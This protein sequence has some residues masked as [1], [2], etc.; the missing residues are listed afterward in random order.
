[1]FKK[2][3]LTMLLFAFTTGFTSPAYA[4]TNEPVYTQLRAV[5]ANTFNE[6]R[7]KITDAYFDLRN[8]YELNESIDAFTANIILDLATKGYNYLPD[9]LS[10]KNYYN[11]LKTSIEKGIKYPN[12]SSNFTEIAKGI[13]DF[14]EKTNIKAIT[15]SVEA[16]PK[17]WNAPLNV[18]LRWNVKDPTG[19]KIPS[20]NYT[21]W[22][23]EDGA[24]KILGD[25]ISLNHIFSEEW[26]FSI[27]LDVKSAHKNENGYTD[28]LPFSSRADITI[29]EKVASLIIKVNSLNLRNSSELNFTPDE[30]IYWLLFDATSSTPTSG[31][32]F[33]KTTW[34][35]W[36]GI[37]RE[38]NWDPRVERV[39]YAREWEFTV[40]LLLKTN[41]L[42]EIE[43]IFVVNVH[44]PIATIRASQDQGFLWDKFTFSAQNST[45]NKNLS[46]SWEII[47]LNKDEVI[48]RKAWNLFTYLFKEKGK[49]NVK[50]RVTEPSWE[51][52]VDSKIIY[53]NSRAPTADFIHNIPSKNK[54]NRVLF[55]ATKSFDLDYS[56]DWKLK[57]SWIINGNRVIL[58]EP[59]FNG[60]T[61]YFTFDSI[62][63]HSVVLD[64]EDP[65]GISSQKKVKVAVKSIL[66]VEYYAFPRV[67]QRENTIRFVSTSPEAKFYEWDFWDGINLWWKDANI[68][69]KFNKS[70][71][72]NVKLTVRDNDDN[73]NS[74]SKNV[75]IWD[76]DSPYS[77][78]TVTDYSKNDLIFDETACNWEWAYMVNRI[79][80]VFFSWKESIDITGKNTGLSYSWKLGQEWYKNSQEFSKKFDE[81]WCFP[82]KLTVKSDANGKVHSATTYVQVKNLKP[83]LS[84]VDVRVVDDWTDPV[85]VNIS[86]LWAKD[87][88]WVIQ[89]YLWYYYTDIDSEPQDFRATKSPST[90]FV[91]PKVTWNYYFVVVMKDNNEERITSEEI[92]GAKYFITLTGDNLNTPLVKLLVDDSSISIWDDITLTASVENILGQDLSNKVKYSWDFDGDWFYDRETT[93]N[94]VSY[95]YISSWEKHAKVKAKYK[96]FS[97]TRSITINVSNVLKP[98]FGY[99]S[100]WS[101]FIFFDKSLWTAESYEWDLWDGIIVKDKKYFVHEYSDSKVSH[102]VKLRIA[103]WTKVKSVEIKVVKNIKNRI[104]ALKE[105]LILFSSPKIDE[106]NKIILKE[107]W[108]NA[109]IY[110]WES[111]PNIVNYIIDYDIDY[112]SDLNGWNDDDSDNVKLDSYVS[113]WIIKVELNKNRIQTIRVFIKDE[114]S[115]VV[116]S[117]DI[118]IQKEY[119]KENEINLNDIIFD[120]IS[121]ITKFKIEK[122]KSYVENLPKEHKL[123]WLM[124]VQKLQEEWWDN[125]EKTN[126]ILEFEGFIYE[127]AVDN[128]EEIIN[129]LESLLVENQEDKSEKAIT[130]N[131]LKNLIPVDI[132]C[133][134]E[135]TWESIQCYNDM[136]FKLEAIRDNDNIDEN[137]IL[138]TEILKVIE[139]D[140]VMTDKQKTDFK[141]IL[142]TFV[143][144][145]IENIPEEE[146]KEV[147]KETETN[148]SS[149]FMW[150]LISV[151]KWLFIIILAFVWIIGLYFIYYLIV[152]KDKNIWFQDFIIEKTSWAKNIEKKES[153]DTWDDILGELNEEKETKEKKE[154][155]LADVLSSPMDQF[156]SNPKIKEDK[157]GEVKEKS[158]EEV[159]KK[160]IKTEEVTID[161]V[162]TEEKSVN[163]DVN[164][165]V[166]DWLKWSFS[167]LEEDKQEKV[168][169]KFIEEVAKKEIKVEEI[170]LDEIKSKEKV[171]VEEATELIEEELIQDQTKIV[172]EENKLDDI[173][174]EE[175]EE[176]KEEEKISDEKIEEIIKIEEPKV[177]EDNIPDW[178]KW[179]FDEDP[180]TEKKPIK[181][182]E[183]K[184]GIKE[185]EKI[186]DEKIEE[187]TKIEEPKVKE[188]N[189]PDWLKWS[190]DEDPKTEKKPIKKVE[191]KKEEIVNKKDEEV[192]REEKK[193]IPKKTFKQ[194][195]NIPKKESSNKLVE[196]IKQEEK[197]TTNEVKKDDKVSFKGQIWKDSTANKNTEL[198]DDWMTIPDW[199]K[200]DD[201]K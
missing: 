108:D 82:I 120:W 61:W 109:Y 27:F 171:I 103:E 16:F 129:L 181:K 54:P 175:K 163:S 56:D 166:P 19:T 85:I 199:L 162:K 183:V 122:L 180:K 140:K 132:V 64:V 134:N 51:T 50:M 80:S 33:I 48:F 93:D 53:I 118:I 176:L 78:I 26:N 81:L 3:V 30:A 178:L 15:W 71:I 193:N 29:K 72:F 76:S 44:D 198:W 152:N 130:F 102:N 200:T 153:F 124:Y 138:W 113:W 92:T 6:Y 194:K 22:M 168:E 43:R 126:V 167:W 1:M 179:S 34:D 41:E 87:K 141:A 137:K 145:W 135:K 46:Y 174:A 89:S 110:M 146:I 112:D 65:D 13:E 117:K 18:T 94:I 116:A 96:W 114:D 17:T 90:S 86:A 24:R 70:G 11:H 184:K 143:Y 23:Y 195:G 10:N 98:D 59:N 95:K 131:A 35:F 133:V 177:K 150:L 149:N 156:E 25:N 28:V 9:S 67:A 157:Q 125:R 127:I 123:K 49:Y 88:D 58:E 32:E 160:E 62:W 161:E 182:V 107:K 4:D 31:T 187:I 147:I 148:N 77:F 201:E 74:F 20:Y 115:I 169:E 99:I 155:K 164:E 83:V 172:S 119:I 144:G 170:E 91:L 37:I 185:E 84:S 21:W 196:E 40:K 136:L 139:V 190:F 189:I 73:I 100:I 45:N 36:N 79:D 158:I 191:V 75:Y 5:D 104:L 57:Y 8:K 151:I 101:K 165:D 106:E 38:Y 111:K 68:S 2:I 188:D 69:H 55:D 97:N 121:D 60:S 154:A 47:D 12:N 128:W 7:Y 159:P 142:K 14:L 42:K 192:K 173:I 52:D 66:S 186:S 63:N 105:W 197:T 39:V